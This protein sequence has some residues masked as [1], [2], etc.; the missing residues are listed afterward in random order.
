[1]LSPK[2]LQALNDQ[3][4]AEFYS[5]YLY[6][7][8]AARCEVLN[9]PGAAKWLEAQAREEHEHAMKLYHYV[10]ERRGEV[11]LQ[12]IK[13]PP[14]PWNNLSEL[15][16]DVLAHEQYITKRIHDLVNLAREEND[17]ASENVLQ[18]FVKEQVEE[19]ASVD[20]I[21]QRLKLVGNMPQALFFI[22]RELGQRS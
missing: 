21:V 2:M 17:Y 10:N 12:A 8:M 1:M 14:S 15:F 19:E 4:N 18:W 9:L 7:A 20:A 13:E 6:L 3:I 5:S 11:K 16:D 22:D